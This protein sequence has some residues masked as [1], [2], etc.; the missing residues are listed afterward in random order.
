MPRVWVVDPANYK[1]LGAAIGP[2]LVWG[3]SLSRT[4]IPQVAVEYSLQLRN[5][6]FLV[7]LLVS[8][9]PRRSSSSRI[10]PMKT[11]SLCLAS[12]LCLTATCGFAADEGTFTIV[13]GGVRALRDTKWYKVAQGARFWEG[14][15]IEGA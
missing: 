7:G 2:L 4:V 15:V 13:D 8:R 3:K 10:E 12:W 5:G 14:D 6:E 9:Y 11:I 1:A